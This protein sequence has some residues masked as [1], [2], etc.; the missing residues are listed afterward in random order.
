[1]RVED[2]GPIG[3]RPGRPRVSGRRSISTDELVVGEWCLAA[4]AWTDRHQHEETNWVLEGELRVTCA[5]RTEIVGPG[6][7]VIIPPGALARYEAPV[8]ARMVFVYGPSRDGHAMSDTRYEEL[9]PT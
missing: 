5:G 6:H 3:P 2:A 9:P 1:M 8:Y 4:A 7:A